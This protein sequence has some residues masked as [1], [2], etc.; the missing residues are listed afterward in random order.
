MY[1]FL[2]SKEQAQQFAYD[3]FDV[4]IRDI[5]AAKEQILDLFDQKEK[6]DRRN[7]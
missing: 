5:K 6:E 2:I 4:I 7:A 3:C 1:D